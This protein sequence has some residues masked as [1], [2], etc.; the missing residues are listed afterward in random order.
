MTIV[1]R[2]QVFFCETPVGETARRDVI[3]RVSLILER[4]GETDDLE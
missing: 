4:C 2:P 3:R 1:P